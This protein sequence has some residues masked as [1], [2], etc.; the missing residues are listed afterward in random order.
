MIS[1]SGGIDITRV[2]GVGIFDAGS[3]L[4]SAGGTA[5]EFD[6]SGNTLT[7]GAGYTISGTVDPPS[8]SNTLALGGSAAASFDLS[9]AGS[10]RQYSGFTVFDVT[11]ADWTLSGSAAVGSSRAGRRRRSPA[12]PRFRAPPSSM[13]VF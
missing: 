3:I 2:S 9:S 4:A 1:G 11:G 13:G 7:L 6:G 8:G 10:G 12:A 5:I